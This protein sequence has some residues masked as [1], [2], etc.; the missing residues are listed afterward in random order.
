MANSGSGNVSAYTVNSSSG[1][2]AAV[3]GSP[4]AAGTTPRTTSAVPSIKRGDLGQS[5]DMDPGEGM[6]EPK[7]F[8]EPQDYSDDHDGIQD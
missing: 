6:E 2:L 3:T 5:S 4:F 7:D 8:Q 1:A